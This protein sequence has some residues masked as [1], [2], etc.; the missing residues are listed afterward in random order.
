MMTQNALR[1]RWKEGKAAV[2]GW[3]A[4]PSAFSAEV[5]AQCGWD[6]ITVDLQHGVQD[7]L[8]MVACF[9]AMHAHPVTRLAR[10]PWN[11]PGIIGKVLD[12]GAYGVVCPMINTKQ[13]CEAL[14]SACR[15]PPK[16]TRSSGPIRAGAYGVPGEYQKTANDEIL[17]IPMIETQEALDNLEAILDVPGID[18]IYVGPGD[19]S[20]SLGLVP[21]LDR[22]EPQ[23]L[24]IYERLIRETNNRGLY[25]GLHCASPVYAARMI[26]S[27]FRLVT[28]ANDSGLLAKA[29]RESV[30]GV[31]AEAGDFR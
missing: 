14:V 16:G 24:Q 2:N 12:G 5:M 18:G 4:I 19:L 23:V 13:Q 7:Y 1:R 17:V 30:A 27:G 6:S 3:L 25:A 26:C 20:F 31:W 22:E 29:A 15:Y 9:Q 10:V 28:I 21:R 8:S 11:E